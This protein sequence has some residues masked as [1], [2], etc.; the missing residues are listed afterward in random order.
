MAGKRTLTEAQRAALALGR[1]RLAERKAADRANGPAK[2]T[3]SP[4]PARPPR[5]SR[6]DPAALSAPT[7]AP[8]PSDSGATSSDSSD[9][10]TNATSPDLDADTL[11]FVFDSAS[12]AP[13]EQSRSG[14]VLGDLFGSLSAPKAAT[15]GATTKPDKR[16]QEVNVAAD[17]WAELTRNL[18]I[19]GAVLIVGQDLK[20]STDEA[21]AVMR[22]LVKILMRHYDP[23]RQ[24][25]ND[26]IDALTALV[27]ITVY[28]QRITPDYRAM[29]A[30]QKLKV[31]RGSSAGPK[32]VPIDRGQQQPSQQPRP[33]GMAAAAAPS[34]SAGLSAS[35][36]RADARA[37]SGAAETPAWVQPA[38]GLTGEAALEEAIGGPLG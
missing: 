33:A 31:F 25:S 18:F 36:V 3:A 7:P 37:G 17:T 10:S 6:P 30:E 12:L 8:T 24:A 15:S 19:F 26:V 34:G 20:P 21:D 9:T 22:P 13:E 23:A 1:Q 28:V 2:R 16:E 4:S 27:A 38:A 32:V 29:K 11:A 35:A 14:G 5:P